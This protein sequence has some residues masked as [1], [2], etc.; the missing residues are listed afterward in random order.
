[1]AT[2]L[3]VDDEVDM[4][5]VMFDLL[6]LDG[7]EVVLA[8]DGEA[9]MERYRNTLPD[10]VITDIL[11]PGVDGIEFLE[12][13]RAEFGDVPVIVMSGTGDINVV[14]KAAMATANRILHKP[15]DAD[16]LLNAV[17][18]LIDSDSHD[19]ESY[20]HHHYPIG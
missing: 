3:V 14:E 4:R 2:I 10:L 1:M 9:A 16:A 7:Y 8:D 11:M 20:S 12:D 6:A 5:D 13:L 18:E 17:A 19:R 15:F